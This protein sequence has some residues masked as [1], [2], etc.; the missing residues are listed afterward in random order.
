MFK[1]SALRECLKSAGDDFGKEIIPKLIGKGFKI[2]V[3]DYDK[4]NSISEF[5]YKVEN[6]KRKRIL[7]DRTVDSS[8]WKD[9]GTIASYYEA[10]MDLISV[11]PIFN[12]YG[13]KWPIRTYQRPLPPSKFI[14]GGRAMSSIIS[15]GCII[16]GAR[17]WHSILSPNVVVEQNSHVEQSIV[18]DDVIIE[19]NVN[20]RYTIIDK[21]ARIQ[22]GASIGYDS[23]LDIQRGCFISDSRIVVVPKGMDIVPA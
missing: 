23:N 5:A 3:Y 1:V 19:P 10:S 9:V 12:L 8:Y 17:I 18:F 7:V 14:F 22:A 16:S 15:E 4:E 20:L 2:L 6:G 13:E 11:A 21:Q